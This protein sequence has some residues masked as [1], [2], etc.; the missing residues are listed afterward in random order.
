MA[1]DLL[2]ELDG[3]IKADTTPS[4][5]IFTKVGFAPYTTFSYPPLYLAAATAGIAI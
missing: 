2:K 3:H 5:D 1:K 4:A